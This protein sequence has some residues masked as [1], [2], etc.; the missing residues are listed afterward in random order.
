MRHNRPPP[1]SLYCDHASRP[2]PTTHD[3]TTWPLRRYLT[4][5]LRVVATFPSFHAGLRTATRFFAYHLDVQDLAEGAAMAVGVAG[6]V[7]NRAPR[8]AA[9]TAADWWARGRVFLNCMPWPT[10]PRWGRSR[11]AWCDHSAERPD[12]RPRR[13]TATGPAEASGHRCQRPGGV[14]TGGKSGRGTQE[15]SPRVAYPPGA[16]AREALRRCPLSCQGGVA[17]GGL[18]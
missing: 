12:A 14:S 18:M 5:G 10:M 9:A 6:A 3:F 1:H 11:S 7:T 4:I 16:A 8:T 2:T 15:R 13:S 17:C